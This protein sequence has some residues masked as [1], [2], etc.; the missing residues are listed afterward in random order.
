MNCWQG[1][2]FTRGGLLQPDVRSCCWRASQFLA[3]EAL[4]GLD[5]APHY[6]GRGIR[7]CDLGLLPHLDGRPRVSFLTNGE[8]CAEPSLDHAPIGMTKVE[9]NGSAWILRR[10]TFTGALL[11]AALRPPALIFFGK[12]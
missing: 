4:D 5:R 11:A 1:G 7:L 10:D 8:R 12:G 2:L 6:S 9:L 3:G